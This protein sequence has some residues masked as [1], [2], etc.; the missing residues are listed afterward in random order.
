MKRHHG[1]II[2]QTREVDMG[3]GGGGGSYLC[4]L[5]PP[6]AEDGEMTGNWLSG[7]SA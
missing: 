5:L 3:G 2:P 7:S 6:G 1:K 4:G